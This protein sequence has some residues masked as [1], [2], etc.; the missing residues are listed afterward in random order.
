M[1]KIDNQKQEWQKPTKGAIVGGVIAG[2]AVQTLVGIVPFV[3]THV[4]MDKMI[5]ISNLSDDEFK[6]VTNGMNKVSILKECRQ[7]KQKHL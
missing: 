3:T 2:S 1:T 4:L 6:Q 5:K 7:P